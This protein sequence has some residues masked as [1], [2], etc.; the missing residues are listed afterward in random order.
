MF[1]K[2]HQVLDITY[3]DTLQVPCDSVLPNQN[4]LGVRVKLKSL[5]AMSELY[6]KV[7]WCGYWMADIERYQVFL[8]VY[9]W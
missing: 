6:G 4:L 7:A 2:L 5:K 8:P 3:E 1:L 9:E